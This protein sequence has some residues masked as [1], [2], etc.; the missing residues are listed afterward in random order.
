[1]PDSRN[2]I[3]VVDVRK[4]FRVYFDKGSTLKEKILRMGS[5]RYE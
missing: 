5:S 3:E 4:K 1:M 2:A